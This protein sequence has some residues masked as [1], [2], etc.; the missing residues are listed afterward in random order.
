MA[1]LSDRLHTLRS[2][3]LAVLEMIGDDWT[4]ADTPLLTVDTLSAIFT[5]IACGHIERNEDRTAYRRTATAAEHEAH[6][7]SVLGIDTAAA[8]EPQR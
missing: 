2:G 6:L 8:E 7:R 3:R 5:L 1:K 4:P